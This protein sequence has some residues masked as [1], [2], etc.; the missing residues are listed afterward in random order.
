M[1]FRDY[2]RA[3]HSRWKTIAV[4]V[5]LALA[6][7]VLLT[8]TATPQYASSVRLLLVPTPASPTEAV[9]AE[10]LAQQRASV[11]ADLAT[12]Q[13]LAQSVVDSTGLPLDPAHVIA[14]VTASVEPSTA[15]LKIT[16]TDP[17]PERAQDLARAY[18]AEMQ[19]LI[20]RL[21]TPTTDAE[22]AT[23]GLDARIASQAFLP[24][25]PSSPR[26]MRNL[27]IALAVG[28]L[29]GLGAALVRHS[30][31][32]TLR[33]VDDLRNA[34]QAPVLGQVGWDQSAREPEL[35]NSM[36]P[37]APRVEAFREVWA[38]LQLLLPDLVSGV[39]MVTAPTPETGKTATAVNVARACAQAGNRTVL[40]ECDLRAPSVAGLL[41]LDA[42][43]G[44]TDV[45]AGTA[46]LADAVH[47]ASSSELDFLGP[48]AV[49]ED[50]GSL[51]TS[52]ALADL[53]SHLIERYDVVVLNAPALAA[54]V[55]VAVLAR[56]ADVVVVVARQ[57]WTT[58][59]EL[60]ASLDRVGPL[61]GQRVGLVFTLARDR[62]GRGLSHLVHLRGRR[63]RA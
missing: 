5:V 47:T 12:S 33:S 45:V 41:G 52:P 43:P 2:V 20:G 54:V 40:V 23:I 38:N 32:T 51:L 34:G 10:V 15:I 53:L 29:V 57:G 39:V 50:P 46:A 16:V 63:R 13:D 28:L 19:T 21:E 58:A 49:A 3:F 27:T 37:D 60:R 4:C 62:A 7:W 44:L 36:P 48:G 30:L 59:A 31:D 9:Q 55:D 8:V 18:G 25:S 14:H 22:G 56:R 6:A 11:Y 61:R 26:P 1:E 42:I 24:S 17:N 35:V